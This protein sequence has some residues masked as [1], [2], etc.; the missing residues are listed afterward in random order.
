MELTRTVVPN[1]FPTSQYTVPIALVGEAPGLDEVEWQTCQSCK[2]EFSRIYRQPGF[3]TGVTRAFCPNCNGNGFKPTPKPFV[4]SSGWLLNQCLAQAGIR[5]ESVFVGNICQARPPDND[6]STFTWD[7]PEIQDG[8]IQLKLDL[9]QF[10]PNLCVL[11]GKTA[12][13]AFLGEFSI[14][15]YR[16]TLFVASG[17]FEGMKCLATYHP[18]YCLRQY[19]EVPILIFD[20]KKA[21]RHSTTSTNEPP[22]R[23][24]E[25]NLSANELISRL[26]SIQTNNTPCS[27][28]IEGGIQSFICCSVA[29]SPQSSF[30][31]PFIRLDGL[32]YWDSEEDEAKVLQAFARV[33]LDEAVPKVFQNC[34]YDRFVLQHGHGIPV[35]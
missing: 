21:K 24:I 22:K 32:S 6:I 19:S 18:A 2:H 13:R 14:M 26:E 16:G 30:L 1:Q 23:T 7:G 15:D 9:D 17:R 31:V 12:L 33:M 34:A 8:L 28:D 35:L 20:L 25:T 10:R 4:G 5:R 3:K 29:R 27:Y 11:L